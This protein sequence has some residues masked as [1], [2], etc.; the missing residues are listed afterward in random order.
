MKTIQVF[1]PAM[2]EAR[3]IELRVLL[4]PAAAAAEREASVAPLR[5][6]TSAASSSV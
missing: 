6:P 2:R 1:D 4:N 5:P 3:R